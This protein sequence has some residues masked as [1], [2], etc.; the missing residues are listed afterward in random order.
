MKWRGQTHRIQL[1]NFV[2]SVFH[3]KSIYTDHSGGLNGILLVNNRINA[4]STQRTMHTI[5]GT[6]IS[7][8]IPHKPKINGNSPHAKAPHASC[9]PIS[10]RPDDVSRVA[11]ITAVFNS[12]IIDTGKISAIERINR[13]DQYVCS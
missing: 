12:T 7:P 10:E 13:Y 11:I 4:A 5:T 9:R 1:S 8:C 2:C 3:C 6:K